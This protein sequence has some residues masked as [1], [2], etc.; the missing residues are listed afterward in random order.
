MKDSEDRRIAAAAAQLS[1]TGVTN[2]SNKDGMIATFRQTSSQGVGG[3]GSS[4][5][6][7]HKATDIDEFANVE[8]ENLSQKLLEGVKSINIR[9]H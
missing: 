2:Q 8:V 3:V 4:T 7:L 1:Q 6:Q 5:D 9:G